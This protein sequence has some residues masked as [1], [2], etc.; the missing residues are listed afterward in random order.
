[1][2]P[3]L[4]QQWPTPRCL[5]SLYTFPDNEEPQLSVW[6]VSKKFLQPMVAL[7]L[8]TSQSA[9]YEPSWGRGGC[10]GV[11]VLWIEKGSASSTLIKEPSQFDFPHFL[12]FSS[13]VLVVYKLGSQCSLQTIPHGHPH[14]VINCVIFQ[15]SS[16]S[17]F[18]LFFFFLEKHFCFRCFRLP[19]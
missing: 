13:S 6:L 8:L 15:I 16:P 7:T 19:E 10:N 12:I 1:M 11:Q 5:A 14:S 9:T 3:I 17:V 4:Q 2:P 18:S